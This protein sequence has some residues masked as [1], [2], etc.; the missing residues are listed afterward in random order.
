MAQT[1]MVR[2]FDNPLEA[3]KFAQQEHDFLVSRTAGDIG[4]YSDEYRPVIEEIGS[5]IP[6]AYEEVDEEPAHEEHE[7]AKTRL[8]AIGE[9][10]NERGG[11]NL[12]QG[13]FYAVDDV[14]PKLALW[15]G[16]RCLESSGWDGIGEW[17]G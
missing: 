1:T 3:L 7:Q 9:M 13:I 12:M 16:M 6:V 11:F 4:N 5:L 2:S 8:H 15:S 14:Y 17:R 10:L